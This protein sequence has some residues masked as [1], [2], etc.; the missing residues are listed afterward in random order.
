MASS[1]GPEFSP[2]RPKCRRRVLNS[3]SKQVLS[4]QAFGD[5]LDVPVNT[6][7]CGIAA[8]DGYPRTPSGVRNRARGSTR[9]RTRLPDTLARELGP[10]CLV[11]EPERR[12]QSM[13]D[14]AIELSDSLRSRVASSEGC[15]PRPGSRSGGSHTGVPCAVRPK[16]PFGPPAQRSRCISAYRAAEAANWEVPVPSVRRSC[17]R[18]M[19]AS[20]TGLCPHC[21]LRRP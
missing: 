7:G 15:V 14:I 11:K 19:A 8:C 10:P 20:A 6:F 18:T 2:A 3:R 13:K 16:R 1:P 12:F 17:R 5:R 21:S 9:I 4:Q